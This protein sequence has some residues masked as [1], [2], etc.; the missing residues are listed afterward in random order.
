MFF[1]KNRSS[2]PLRH[3][4]WCLLGLLDPKC[5]GTTQ[6]LSFTQEGV[7]CLHVVGSFLTFAMTVE[8][9]HIDP[10]K[11]MSLYHFLTCLLPVADCWAFCL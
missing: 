7:V 4:D 6:L 5:E 10:I 8:E 2:G 11:N 9:K 1:V 3:T